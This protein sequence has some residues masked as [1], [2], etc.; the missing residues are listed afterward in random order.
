MYASQKNFR[1]EIFDGSKD[2][3]KDDPWMKPP[4]V[5]LWKA[6]MNKSGREFF[7]RV[8]NSFIQSRIIFSSPVFFFFY[9]VEDYFF[10]AF[11]LTSREFLQ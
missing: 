10:E 7:C 6:K 11:F 2:E 4:T 8:Q 9:P 1:D 3:D 5:S